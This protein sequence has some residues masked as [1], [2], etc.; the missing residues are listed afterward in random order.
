VGS[1]ELGKDADFVLFDRDPMD[2]HAHVV[3]TIIDGKVV[4]RRELDGV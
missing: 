2:I 4:Y 1:I 3:M